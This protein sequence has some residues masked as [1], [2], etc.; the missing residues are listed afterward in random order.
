AVQAPGPRGRF[1]VAE[2]LSAHRHRHR[3]SADVPL[4]INSGCPGLAPLSLAQA[5]FARRCD[6][7]GDCMRFLRLR[8]HAVPLTT[9]SL[10]RRN[11][12]RLLGLLLCLSQVCR[13]ESGLPRVEPPK[14][15]LFLMG[16]AERADNPVVW[17]EL[18]RLAGGK[19]A[20]IAI[21][22]TGSRNPERSGAALAEQLRDLGLDPFVVP[23]ARATAS[24]TS[25][26]RSP[27]TD[28][29]WVQRLRPA[30]D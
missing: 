4:A 15:R 20:R 21:F 6:T 26:D 2:P 18:V 7:M 10:P 24:G 1:L 17:P 14:G 22:A 25:S 27:T 29:P 3:R 12:A 8:S 23:V 19:G 16:G 11:S 9:L 30:A 5:L 28:A 13:A